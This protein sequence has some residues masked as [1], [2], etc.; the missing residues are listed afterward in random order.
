[1]IK[2]TF[3]DGSQKDYEK[4]IT[5]YEIAQGISISLAKKAVAAIFN[6]GYVELN[7]ALVED[8]KLALLTEKDEKALDVINHSTAHL[9]A[10]AIVSLYPQACFGVGPYIEEGFYYDVDFGDE[11]ISDQ[12]LIKIEKKMHE[13]AEQGFDVLREE[14]SYEEAKN[15]FKH[16][17]YKLEIIEDYKHTQLTVYRQGDFVDLCRGGHVLNTKQIK[18]FKLLNLAGAYWRGNS[19][20]KMLVRIYGT[21]FFSKKALDDHLVLL[22]ERKQRDHRKLGKELGLFMISKEAGQGLP[23]WLPKGATIRR[24]IERYITDVEISLGYMH[25]YTPIL[26]NVDVYKTSGHWDHYQDSMFP[27]MDMG[28]GEMLV[29]RPMNC[30]HHMIMYKNDVHSYRE[31]P[32]RIAELGMMHRYEKSGALSGLQRVREMTLNDAHIFVRP[33]QIKDE[34]KRTMELLLAVYKDFNITDYKFR[35]SYRDPEDTEKYFPN[36]EMWNKAERML[37]EALDEFGVE[38][39]E[40]VGEAAFYGPKLDVQVKTALGNSETLSTIQLDF[41]LPE[42]FDLT[43][44]GED[45]KNDQRPVVIHRGIVSTMERFVAYLTEEY[46]GAFPFWLAPVQVKVLP[47]NV[48]VH[49]DYVKKVHEF[50]KYKGYRVESDLR[51]EKLGYKIREAQTMKIPYALVLGDKE[52]ENNEVTYRRYGETAQITVSLEDFEKMIQKELKETLK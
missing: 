39:F 5:P 13:L 15:I 28:D 17:P 36:D 46:K 25:V 47:V 8:G 18:H 2:I 49:M 31:L 45:G 44:V 21:S 9:M 16:D 29:I 38:Y 30:P 12:D 52:A 6:D 27:P 19:D 50:L 40:A 51:E 35:L 4:G 41:L 22:E 23:F 3:P 26:A 43:Y 11:K 32:L 33:D 34:F 42:R 48:S 37:K 10:Q 14:V 20:N 24:V 1:M 7:R